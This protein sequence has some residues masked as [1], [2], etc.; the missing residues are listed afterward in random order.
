MAEGLINDG[1]GETCIA[2]LLASEMR[3]VKT[4]VL[5]KVGVKI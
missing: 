1:L 5:L 2:P 4:P 3:P